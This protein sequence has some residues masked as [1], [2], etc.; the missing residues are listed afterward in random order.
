MAIAKDTFI[1]LWIGITDN[2]I[3]AMQAA[4]AALATNVEPRDTRIDKITHLEEMIEDTTDARLRG[5][6]IEQLE[7]WQ[8]ME[9][10]ADAA[11]ANYDVQIALLQAQSTE[12]TRLK[13]AQ[14]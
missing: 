3:S 14:R 4:K 9:D 7:K 6:F 11:I 13:T 10:D 5:K 12:L 1:D 8:K 2:E